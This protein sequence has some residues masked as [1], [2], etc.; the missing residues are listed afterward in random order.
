[1]DFLV[2]TFGVVEVKH[3]HHDCSRFHSAVSDLHTNFFLEEE[4]EGMAIYYVSPVF[5]LFSRSFWFGHNS[6]IWLEN[7]RNCEGALDTF[8]LSCFEM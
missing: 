7:L 8:M 4:G 5:T 6:R 3:D 1:M 2:A